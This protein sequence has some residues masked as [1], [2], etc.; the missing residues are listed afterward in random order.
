MFRREPPKMWRG[1]VVKPERWVV[2]VPRLRLRFREL[3]YYVVG[4]A[5]LLSIGFRFFG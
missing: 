4:T 2:R 3:F 5:I 1:Q